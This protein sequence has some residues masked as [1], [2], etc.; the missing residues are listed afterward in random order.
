MPSVGDVVR[1]ILTMTSPEGGL[2]QNIFHIL[3]TEVIVAEWENVAGGAEEWLEDMYEDYMDD[4]NQEVQSTQVE[5]L[6]RDV[7]A[8]EWNTVFQRAFNGV[9]GQTLLDT[10]PS[11]NTATVVAFP[12]LPRF[13]GFK[14]LPPVSEGATSGGVLVPSVLA[15]L[16]LFAGFYVTGRVGA[17]IS[18]TSGVYSEATETYRPFTDA[19]KL[20]DVL[21]TRVTR[22]SGRGI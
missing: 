20:T 3:L 12:A 15:N 19:V 17:T 11:T 2:M 5:I 7:G 1:V 8:G 13:W 9:N 18:F 21:G 14:S 10:L 6:E 16:L 22:K 4:V